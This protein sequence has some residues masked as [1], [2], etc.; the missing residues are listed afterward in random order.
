VFA[1]QS[2]E[3]RLLYLVLYWRFAET[4]CAGL[5][6]TASCLRVFVVQIPFLMSRERLTQ[7][8]LIAL[9]ASLLALPA[10]V[11]KLRAKP[12]A[13]TNAKSDPS[14][15]MQRYGMCLT[16]VA[17]QC[18][19]DFVHT[20]PTFD[21]KLAH[22]M[23]QIASMG[24]SVSIVDF[25]LDGW[26]DIYVTNSGENS[27]NHLY[28]NNRD[29]TFKDVADELGIA[30]VN[31]DGTG[32]S[33]GAVW[34]DYDND[35]Y[36]DL[37]LYKYGRPE[38]FHND[39]G[40][41]F[42]RVT[43]TASL[44]KWV[45]AN[46][47]IWVDYDRD[48]RVDIFLCG[49]FDEKLDLWHLKDTKMMPESFE[50]AENGGRKYLLH[51]NGD[52]AFV[53]VTDKAGINTRRW[54]L[55]VAA[56]DLC[57][58]GCPDLFLANDYGVPELYQNNAGQKFEEIGKKIG[59]GTG[60]KSGMNASFGDILNR[61]CLA[62]YKTNISEEGVLIQGN[63]LW[64]PNLD[65]SGKLRSYANLASEMGVELG[66]W[67]WGA[68][69]GDLNNDGLLDLYMVNGSV[70][71]DRNS[72][73]WY[74]FSKIAGGHSSI[75]SDAANWPLMGNRSLSGYQQK[76]L[77]LSDGAGKFL[78]VAQP[79][80]ATDTFDGRAVAFADLWNRGVLDIIVANQR[81]PLLIYKNQCQ[82]DNAWVDFDLEG[83]PS[84][85]SAIGA[86]VHVFW[87]GQQQLQEVS[88]G[89]GFSSQN[90]RRLHFGLGRNPTI[91]KVEVRWPSGQKQ[92]LDHVE[93]NKLHRL[94]EPRSAK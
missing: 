23:P 2:L 59:I 21:P 64:L 52:G 8:L 55:A 49:Y 83:A 39:A 79:V 26:N 76:K 34:A 56:A 65:A 9:L 73:Y 20:A 4:K 24:A 11:Q 60:P 17:K 35:G 41:H 29:G 27:R 84:N 33:M 62:I 28:R 7:P 58:N 48:G 88:G 36:E 47:A 19:I 81:G 74:D 37:L 94:T 32:V 91:E 85:R 77:W 45:N 63:D 53:D 68:Q 22:I 51:N 18:G 69:F 71:A 75:I 89:S 16:E 3:Q 93:L 38:L 42:A 82:P 46:S 67:S 70:S 6:R 5:P 1:D 66:G 90:Q 54:T 43:E 86:Q 25:D 13:S 15:T 57:G 92:T 61:G 31:R 44:P 10:V 30:D 87:S 14:A 40:K 12:V 50:Y 80:G 78:E 72:S